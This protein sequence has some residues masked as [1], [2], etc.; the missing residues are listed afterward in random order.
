MDLVCK[1]NFYSYVDH[2]NNCRRYCYCQ[3]LFMLVYTDWDMYDVDVFMR[4][5]STIPPRTFNW[6]SIIWMEFFL[7]LTGCIVSFDYVTVH[8]IQ[9]QVPQ[10]K[11]F[12]H[13][14]Y[15]IILD[16]FC[17]EMKKKFCV[18]VRVGL[19]EWVNENRKNEWA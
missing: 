14:L 15:Y 18:C 3:T 6:L 11:F 19:I 12:F 1:Y 7:K 17:I 10:K 5:V 8:I 16:L 4:C 9:V 13:L 2:N